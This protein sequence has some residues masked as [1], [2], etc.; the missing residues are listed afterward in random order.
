MAIVTDARRRDL[1]TAEKQASEQVEIVG[2]GL[3]LRAVNAQLRGASPN[4][5]LRISDVADLSGLAAGLGQGEVVVDGDAGDYL[6]ALNHGAN[7]RVAGDVGCYLADNMTR[8]AV[9]VAGNA[10]Y[11]AAPYCYGGVV[12]INGDAGDFTAVMNK[13]ATVIVG[14][15]VGDDVATYMLDGDVIVVGNAGEN[16]A[17]YLIRGNIYVGGEWKSLGHNTKVEDITPGDA[18]KLQQLFDQYGIG[19]EPSSFR[20][21]RP[22]SEK[23]FYKSKAMAQPDS[24]SKS[25]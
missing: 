19:A 8:G 18:S 13:G 3:D 14:G 22:V 4:G 10:G 15:N 17:N 2:T 12:V 24:P 23:P 20:K 25:A 16:L 6:A 5:P 7:V 1:L 9:V 11:A 21:V